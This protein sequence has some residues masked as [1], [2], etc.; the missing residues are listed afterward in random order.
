[1]KIITLVVSKGDNSVATL[2]LIN[3]ETE[4]INCTNNH[5]KQI[6]HLLRFT[7]NKSLD[8]LNYNCYCFMKNRKCIQFVSTK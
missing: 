2:Y 7:E 5:L 8:Y 3:Q 6:I 4:S 1:M